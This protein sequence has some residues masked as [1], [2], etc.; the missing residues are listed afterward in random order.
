MA[1]GNATVAFTGV[2]N[3]LVNLVTLIT[4]ALGKIMAS[5][6]FGNG[7]ACPVT[8]PLLCFQQ[9]IHIQQ[10]QT[11]STQLQMNIMFEHGAGQYLTLAVDAGLEGSQQSI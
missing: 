7:Q 4:F 10:I 5:E 9:L 2:G 8:G 3:C 11:T 1:C 6:C